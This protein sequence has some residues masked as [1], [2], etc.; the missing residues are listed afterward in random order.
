MTLCQRKYIIFGL[1]SLSKATLE[2][3]FHFAANVVSLKL[4]NEIGSLKDFAHLKDD[5]G[6]IGFALI[7]FDIKYTPWGASP[8]VL[9][10]HTYMTP[11]FV[12]D[13]F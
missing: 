6:A 4:G 11:L 12:L 9:K 10:D 3:N 1:D 7:H 2:P 13:F 8:I 5:F